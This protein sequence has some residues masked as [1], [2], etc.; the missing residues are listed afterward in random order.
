M[1]VYNTAVISAH[2]PGQY[3]D[4]WSG[5]T[6][7]AHTEQDGE[8]TG[9][10]HASTEAAVVVACGS[11]KGGE[12][13]VEDVF[14]MVMVASVRMALAV[15]RPEIAAAAVDGGAE[16]GVAGTADVGAGDTLVH[17]NGHL[18]RS[19]ELAWAVDVPR[20]AAGHGLLALR[21]DVNMKRVC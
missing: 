15:V 1:N 17:A 4:R 11:G 9:A 16:A 19:D 3:A 5:P 18:P 6:G 20:R 13:A 7:P 8:G 21:P 2:T 14:G 10:A 12:G